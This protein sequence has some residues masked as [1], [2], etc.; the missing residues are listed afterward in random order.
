M[1]D[2]FPS[3]IPP[4][5]HI[6][7]LILWS[8]DPGN[9]WMYHSNWRC[10]DNNS[11]QQVSISSTSLISKIGISTNLTTSGTG[12]VWIAVEITGSQDPLKGS[13]DLLP[14][15]SSQDLIESFFSIFLAWRISFPSV[16]CNFWNVAT[17]PL[18]GGS[19]TIKLLFDPSDDMAKLC[20]FLSTKCF[21]LQD[22]ARLIALRSNSVLTRW[23]MWSSQSLKPR[24]TPP[25]PT[26]SYFWAWQEME[27][28]P[29][30][31]Y[32]IGS[33]QFQSEPSTDC[34]VHQR[35]QEEPSRW[36]LGGK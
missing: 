22:K 3:S 27:G 31:N 11:F 8:F 7:W 13:Q 21:I 14:S 6:N 19:D 28:V 1:R 17:N 24:G 5:N 4:N 2:F 33:H 36:Y 18:K 32:L 29:W 16:D 15:W 20:R 25:H 26:P 35:R 9:C 10:W 34:K 12:S 30:G 23:T